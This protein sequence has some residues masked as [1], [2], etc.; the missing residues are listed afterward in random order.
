MG[1]SIYTPGHDGV[2]AEYGLSATVSLLPLAFYNLGMGLG[3]IVGTPMSE[4]FGRRFV[5]LTTQPT[6]ALFTL[7]AGFSQS[8][9]AL[10][11]C[12][13]FAGVFASPGVSIASA[14]ISDMAAPIH[15]AIPMAFYYSIPFNGSLLGYV[16]LSNP[17]FALLILH[18]VLIGGFVVEGK[19]WRWTQWTMLFFIIAF[20]SPV[21]FMRES[22]KKSIL[23][24]RAKRL[25]VGGPSGPQRSLGQNFQYFMTK[26]VI[27]PVHM[28][29]TEP[30]VGLVCLYSSFQF[31]L[32]Y[33]FVVASPYTFSNVYDFSLGA[34]GLSFVGFITGATLV[35]IPLL[36]L[37]HYV[38]QR[39][40]AQFKEDTIGEEL[41]TTEFPPE[42]R[43]YSAMIGSVVLPAGL[44]WFAWT[45]RSSV[46]WIIPIIAQAVSIIG[47]ILVYVGANIYMMDTYG[48]L[49][50]ASA[51]GATSLS[52]YTLA[53]AFPLFTLQMYQRL[54]VHWATSLLGFCTVAMAPIPWVFY[55]WG[56]KLRARS[57]YERVD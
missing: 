18:S 37:D 9:T 35:P 11:I 40:W 31:A 43:L 25:G 38:Y 24:S 20:V 22:Y 21:I 47:S 26:T 29:L 4:T 13:F 48:P 8:I 23:E 55:R 2:A 44:F 46:H 27:R 5:Y 3:P 51:A 56:P 7:G 30:I 52:R 45:A 10:I 16:C 54:G 1:A 49:Y 12:R 42:H 6:F 15:R 33:T 36:A 32:L 19:G 39:K 41:G 57:G 28:L 17:K 50:G 53:T 34:Q 14:T